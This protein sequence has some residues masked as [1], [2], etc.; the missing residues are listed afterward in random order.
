ML[1]LMADA[2]NDW[3]CDDDVVESDGGCAAGAGDDIGDALMVP[4]VLMMLMMMLM[5]LVVMVLMVVMVVMVAVMMHMMVLI[6]I[7]L[8][9]TVQSFS[10][11][12]VTGSQ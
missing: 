5:L 8:C 1:L 10:S 12:M 3:A 11:C 7:Q 6:H 2:D 9:M 4:I